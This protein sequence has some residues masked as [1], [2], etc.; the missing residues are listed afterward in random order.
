MPPHIAIREL[1][2]LRMIS[3]GSPFREIAARMRYTEAYVKERSKPLYQA[4]GARDRAHAVRRGFELGL[5]HDST[6]GERG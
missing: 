2:I 1:T 5:L 3:E 4:I 6:E